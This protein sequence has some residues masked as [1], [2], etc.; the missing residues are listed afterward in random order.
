M[1]NTWNKAGTTW[2]YNSWE[3]DTVTVSL[4][5]ISI[6]ASL[7]DLAYAASTEGWGRDQWSQNDWGS[8]T[9]TVSVT[10]LS[11]TG[12]LGDLAYAGSTSGWGRDEWGIGNWGEN[13][14][15]VI[16]D[17]LEMTAGLG[18]E[19]W[20]RDTWGIGAWGEQS[21]VNIEI[22]ESLTGFSITGSLGTPQ[23][24][25]DF[26][27]ILTDSLL[28]TLSLGSLSINNGADHTQGLP[29]VQ[30]SLLL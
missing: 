6:T 4:T 20:G 14:T 18:L 15:T 13:I 7:A 5:G 30:Y 11:M 22:G 23:I 3:S 2:G 24:N 1:A 10:G 8:D 26:K 17:G 25:Y 16:P 9:N 29:R 12:A 28:G 27:H 19:G 21:T